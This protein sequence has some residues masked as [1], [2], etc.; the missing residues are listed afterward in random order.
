MAAQAA[1]QPVPK[2]EELKFK[3]KSA[4]RYVGKGA[5]SYDL[6]EIVTGKAGY[7]M[8][9]HMPGMLFASVAS[10]G[11]GGKVKSYDEKAPLQV[12]GVEQTVPIQPFKPPHHFQPLG[13][14][15]VI[16]DNTWAAFL[17]PQETERLVGKRSSR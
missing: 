13:G 7:G 8:D 10:A 15:A 14:V 17:G 3:P 12:A 1:K 5:K 11:L 9:V 4:R 6:N 16:A 2:K